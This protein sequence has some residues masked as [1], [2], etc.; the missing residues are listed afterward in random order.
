MAEKIKKQFDKDR[1]TSTDNEE[2]IAY[3]FGVWTIISC[4]PDEYNQI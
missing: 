3:I 4:S 2:F 1:Y